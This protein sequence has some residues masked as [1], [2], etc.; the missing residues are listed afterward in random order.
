MLKDLKK[1]SFCSYC[2]T[3]LYD[4]AY[5]KQCSNCKNYAWGNPLPI[6]VAVL[7]VEKNDQIGLIIQQRNI[8]PQKNHWAL[9]GGYINHRENWQDAASRE[10]MEELSL[11]ADASKFK[12]LY[13]SGGTANE[14][15]QIICIYDG[16]FSAAELEFA[17]KPNNEVQAVDII[18]EPQELAFPSHTKVAS[19]ILNMISKNHEVVKYSHQ[20][21]WEGLANF[22]GCS[23]HEVSTKKLVP[24]SR[25]EQLLNSFNRANTNLR[26]AEDALDAFIRPIVLE[27]LNAG[28]YA[29][30][31]RLAGK[32]GD[33]LTQVFLLDTIREHERNNSGKQ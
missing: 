30:A 18:F 31:R 8:D 7:P 16:I 24:I 29:E 12:L 10:T 3:T 15:I 14:V 26:K 23:I 13:V 11:S 20:V 1:D 28:N 21:N 9:T 27:Y 5:P 4:V 17:F 22:L 25:L 19:E 6:V 32:C 2:G 33:S